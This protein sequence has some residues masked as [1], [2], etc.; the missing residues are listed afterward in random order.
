M[1]IISISNQRTPSIGTTDGSFQGKRYFTCQ[2][3]CG[4]FLP[5][6]LLHPTEEIPSQSKITQRLKMPTYAHTA[7]KGSIPQS[8]VNPGPLIFKIGERVAFY[9]IKGVKHY[10]VIG[11]AGRETKARKFPYVIVGIITVSIIIIIA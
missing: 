7:T 11:W 3:G 2:D 4:L 6:H 1:I 9:S 8:A 5:L 10:G